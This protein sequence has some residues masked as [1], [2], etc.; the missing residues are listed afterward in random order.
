MEKK[1][2]IASLIASLF[3]LPGLCGAAEKQ[4]VPADPAAERTKSG[5][6]QGWIEG[7]RTAFKVGEAITF[8]FHAGAEV[9]KL[10][11][12]RW[13]DD[14]KEEKLET[15]LTTN[16]DVRVTTSL[17]KPGT[18]SV[19]AKSGDKNLVV[20][21]VVEFEK[22]RG[23][24]AGAP[25]DFD[26]F[27]KTM[28]EKGRAE[29]GKAKVESYK[30]SDCRFTALIPCGAAQ[31]SSIGYS[32]PKDAKPKSCD[33]YFSFP[34]WSPVDAT[35]VPPPV[36][37]RIAVEFN[38]HGAKC[39]EK[40]EYHAAFAKEHNL[41]NYCFTGNNQDRE[42]TYYHEMA[43][44]LIAALE[45]V[46]TLPAWSGVIHVHGGSQGGF[47]SILAASLDP[48]V[49]EVNAL[50]PWM[51]DVDSD[52]RGYLGGWRPGYTDALAYYHPLHH[53]MRFRAD[54][55]V[56]LC[57]GLGDVTCRPFGI[58]ALYN[59][60][61]GVERK[62]IDVYQSS[63]HCMPSKNGKLDFRKEEKR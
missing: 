34:G 8:R 60:I 42:Q 18:V 27:W 36:P 31:P 23:N 4:V 30:G 19:Q 12:T 6:I 20:T 33:A 45:Y 59:A 10:A 54:Q 46:K 32:I 49:K 22:I 15:A 5:P 25:K 50:Y 35:G 38:V 41:F 1:N 40:M 48:T 28:W 24:E 43:L 14:R 29:V 7:G 16:D 51:C 58:I 13:G 56:H 9:S 63:M 55:K 57:A 53:A 52:V 44:R 47:L 3:L 61:H 62:S 39:G 26:A 2:Y 17:D 37:K 21:A 11:L